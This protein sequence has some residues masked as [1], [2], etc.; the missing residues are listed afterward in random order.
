MK[1]ILPKFFSLLCPLDQEQYEELQ[2]YLSSKKCR[3][4][5]NKRVKKFSEM[6]SMIK[7]FCIRGETNDCDRCMVCGV[8]WLKNAIAINNR[9]LSL[10]IEKCKSSI[11][12]SLQRMG[13]IPL[14]TKSEI[15]NELYER[16]P[17][18]KGNF[19]ELREWSLRYLSTQ[20]PEP[21]V[22]EGMVFTSPPEKCFQ[23]P[24][25]NMNSIEW[26]SKMRNRSDMDSNFHQF[27]PPST[28]SCSSP[29]ELNNDSEKSRK[30]KKRRKCKKR[31]P[32]EDFFLAFS[33]E[34]LEN[35]STEFLFDE[36]TN[37]SLYNTMNFISS[38]FES[39]PNIDDHSNSKSNI[40]VMNSDVKSDTMNSDVKSDIMN[41]DVKS[42]IMNSDVKRNDMKADNVSVFQKYEQF[43]D[44]PLCIPLS[45]MFDNMSDFPDDWNA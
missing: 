13:Y 19:V 2:S 44:D 9:Q 29:K 34:N 21:S 1:K 25:P 45:S 12:G 16:I 35:A 30:A 33:D 20:T 6:L 43:F 41:S 36:K 3:N 5:R 27:S 22:P 14:T 26:N 37:N 15:V 18:L 40:D 32:K 24:Q 17:I 11:N 38:N 4:N 10:L 28:N 42:D 39:L 31:S 7:D 8:C 23:S